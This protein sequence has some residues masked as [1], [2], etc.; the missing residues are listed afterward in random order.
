MNKLLHSRVV[1]FVQNSIENLDSL[2]CNNP[3]CGSFNSNPNVRNVELWGADWS[4]D[5]Y[6]KNNVDCCEVFKDLIDSEIK[7]VKQEIDKIIF[8]KG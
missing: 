4:I 5:T 8:G 2:K 6:I 7:L 3:N 1:L